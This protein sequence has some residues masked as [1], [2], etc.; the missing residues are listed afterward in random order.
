V[1]HVFPD[2]LRQEKGIEDGAEDLTIEAAKFALKHRL[3]DKPLLSN[4]L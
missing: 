2:R 1:F 3:M 4:G